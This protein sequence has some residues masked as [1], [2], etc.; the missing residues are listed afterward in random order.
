[1]IHPATSGI[2]ASRH[3]FRPRNARELLPVPLQLFQMPMLYFLKS[4]RLFGTHFRNA[5]MLLLVMYAPQL[6][7][8]PY[9]DVAAFRYQYSPD[10]GAYRRGYTPNHFSFGT[11]G[12]NIPIVFKDSSILLLG[13]SIEQ[14]DITT[15]LTPD[16]PVLKG[17]A[18]PLTAVKPFSKTW[19]GTFIFIPRWNGSEHFGFKERLQTGGAVLLTYKK[20]TNLKYKFGLYYNREFF[21][22][23]FV[24]LAGIEWKINNRLQLFGVLP[25]SLV[26][27]RKV[28]KHFYYGASFRSITTSFRYGDLKKFMRIDD[29]QLQAFADLYLS[30]NIVLNAEAGHSVFRRFRTGLPHGDPKYLVTEKFNDNVLLRVSLLYRVRFD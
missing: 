8:Q 10:A 7:A 25:G 24:P 14:W 11:A 9:L 13:P 27:E 19:T 21:G 20:R 30:K 4:R 28:S 18:L 29:N 12:L 16:V 22:N 3:R 17:I 1:M 23:F 6:R 26:L 15:P 2:H 5:F